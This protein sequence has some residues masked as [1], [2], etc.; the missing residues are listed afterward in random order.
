MRS[1]GWLPLLACLLLAAGCSRSGTVFGG[2]NLNRS[3]RYIRVPKQVE[4]VNVPRLQK[5]GNATYFDVILRNNDPR[6][7]VWKLEYKFTFYDAGGRVLPSATKGWRPLALGRGEP[8]TIGGCCM[9]QGAE[10][11]TCTL[12]RWDP[13]N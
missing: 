9:I 12:R 7:K 5:R 6:R 1:T 4:V 3:V 11:A 2:G 8:K 13:R 10:S